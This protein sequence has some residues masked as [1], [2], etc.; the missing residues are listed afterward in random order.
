VSYFYD[1]LVNVQKLSVKADLPYVPWSSA[2][3]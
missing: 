2:W 3:R 1:T